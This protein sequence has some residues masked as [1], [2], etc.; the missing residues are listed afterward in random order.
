MADLRVGEAHLLCG[1]HVGGVHA[2]KAQLA[3]AALGGDDVLDAVEEP[4]VDAGELEDALQRH[5]RVA[6]EHLSGDVADAHEVVGARL[7][8]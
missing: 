2:G 1:Q 6:G 4:L 3:D 7:H 5:A 8:G